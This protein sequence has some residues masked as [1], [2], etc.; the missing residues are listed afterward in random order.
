MM[1]LIDKLTQFV[2]DYYIDPILHDSGYNIVNTITWAIL[3]GICIF[4]VVKLLKRLD[5]QID[6]KLTAAIVPFVLAGSS[7]RVIEDTGSIGAPLSYLFITPNIYFLVFAVTLC[8][9]VLSKWI[10]TLKGSG[11]YMKI[12][13]VCGLTWFVVNLMVL[14]YLENL[15][16][17][18]V[19]VFV[20][21]TSSLVLYIIKSILDRAGLDLLKSR[22]NIAILWVHFMDASSTIAGIDFLGYYEKHVVPAYLIDL[23]G[24]AFVMYPLKLSI[25]IP[26]LYLLDKH[27]D[28]DEESK[29]LKTFLKMVIIVLGLSPACR[30]TIRMAFGV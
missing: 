24:T 1:P 9:L 2:N 7:L 10:V 27:F 25:F 16:L 20:I 19:P 18:W 30:N 21:T 26:V 14:F 13:A 17:P 4:G 15:V 22:I 8:F 5:V 29:T 11:D 3:L 6:N 12:F 28:Q 23:T